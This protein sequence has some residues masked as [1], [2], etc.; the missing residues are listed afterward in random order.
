MAFIT[1]EGEKSAPRGDSWQRRPRQALNTLDVN[2][3]QCSTGAIRGENIKTDGKTERSST[4]LQHG[5]NRR[6]KN[7]ENKIQ[8]HSTPTLRGSKSSTH[9]NNSTAANKK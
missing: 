6:T 8:K 5:C 9:N 4:R 2:R 7:P 1:Y 3:A